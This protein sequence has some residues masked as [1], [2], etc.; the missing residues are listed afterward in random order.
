MCGMTTPLIQQLY[1]A[2]SAPEAHRVAYLDGLRGIAILAVIG[3]HYFTR[4]APDAKHIY[5]YADIWAAFIPFKLGYYGVQ[6][7]FAISGFVI[8][9]S[10]E[11]S[12]SIDEF[13]VRRF[14]RLWPT[15]L[16]CSVI[17][18]SVLT[19]WPQFW[20]QQPGNFLPSLTLI[21]TQFW[22]AIFPGLKANWIDGSY[23]TL[24]VELRFYALAALI[25][26]FQPKKFHTHFNLFAATV[27]VSYSGLR[28]LGQP[29]LAEIVQGAFVAKYLPWFLLGIAALHELRDAHA[30]AH[31]TVLLAAACVFALAIA[32]ESKLD[33]VIFIVV[34]ALLLLPQKVRGLNLVLSWRPL[35]GI[36]VVSYS[37]Y[38]LH[39]NVGLTL[40]A[41]IA[42]RLSLTGVQALPVAFLVG[43][44]LIALSRQ[45]FK[46]WESPLNKALVGAYMRLKCA[47]P[48]RAAE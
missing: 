42:E 28:L 11:R 12:R 29:H 22:S 9:L 37:L 6:L 33:F 1:P 43:I 39:Q 3:Y 38:L 15:M 34:T 41:V 21:D 31:G 10:L 18:Y 40:I 26:F 45:I 19:L 30:K 35:T 17:S 44:A 47:T 20:P 27:V 32:G 36:G 24:F 4:W 16:L 13:A 5:P 48:F 14:S 23:W 46:R 7:F 25:Y 2:Q 8:A